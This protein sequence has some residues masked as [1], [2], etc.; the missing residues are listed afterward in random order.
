MKKIII[1]LVVLLG[2]TL[3][4]KESLETKMFFPTREAAEKAF[5]SGDFRYY[6]SDP[7]NIKSYPPFSAKGLPRSYV[8][9]EVVRENSGKSPAWVLLAPGTPSVFNFHGVPIQDGR[10]WNKILEAYPVLLNGR[11]GKDGINGKDGQNGKDGPPGK[12]GEIV[13]IPSEDNTPS[14]W[15]IWKTLT[16]GGAGIGGYF[17]G[18]NNFKKTITNIT[19]IPPVAVQTGNG[20]IIYGPERVNVS[21]SNEFNEPIAIMCGL[22]SAG[23]TFLLNWFVF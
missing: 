17:I 2:T 20:T 21:T 9:L 22:L 1:F 19:R 23:V 14:N 11:D 13:I 15:T 8:V 7:K 6:L 3:A 4:Q 5:Y 16:T 10:C 12:D 18:H